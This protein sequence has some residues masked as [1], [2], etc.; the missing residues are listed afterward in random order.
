MIFVSAEYSLMKAFIFA[1]ALA[2]TLESCEGGTLRGVVDKSISRRS[3]VP[4]RANGVVR[5]DIVRC[6][7]GCSVNDDCQVSQ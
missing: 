3:N 1:S 4:R 6:E 7:P 2:M 5:G